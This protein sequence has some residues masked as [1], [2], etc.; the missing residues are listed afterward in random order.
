MLLRRLPPSAPLG[1]LLAVLGPLLPQR[2]PAAD[3]CLD[4]HDRKDVGNGNRSVHP[5]FADDDCQ[6]CHLDHGDE[7]RLVL[8]ADGN[9]LCDSCHDT[10]ERAFL[11]AHRDVRGPKARCISCHDPHRSAEEQLLTPNRHRPLAFGRCDPC[12]RY[13]GR[14]TKPVGELCLGCH[15]GEEFTRR[16]A[17]APVR[18]GECLSC[19]DPHASREP[20][21]L[22]ARY[23]PGRG[24]GGE[25]DVALCLRCHDRAGYFD[26]G[27]ERT[28]FRAGGRNY[29]ALHLLAPVASAAGAGAG[30]RGLSCRACHEVHTSEGPRLVR[31]ELDCGGVPCLRLDFRRT[32][33][34]GHCL[35]GCHASQSYSFS[36]GG[37]P[38]PAAVQALLLAQEPTY[39]SPRAALLEP[40]ALEE[41]INRRCVGCH[42]KDV[43][44]FARGRGHAPVQSG[45]CSSCH[46]DHGPE[47]RLVL[48]GP[49]DRVCARCHDLRGEAAATAHRGYP[50][51]GSRCTECHDPHGAEA[52]GLVLTRRHPPF[53]EGDCRSCH[54]EPARGWRI[55]GGGRDTCGQC[56][57]EI[58]RGKHRH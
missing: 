18:R 5:P 37:E 28:L 38:L 30:A 19:H 48:L 51:E 44:R 41:S 26:G 20:F 4:C 10:Q 46:L 15:G 8:S 27:A 36:R 21:L 9:A 45:A 1:I 52:A 11:R 39:R 24:S 42:E 16:I 17:H 53:E 57:D 54:G 47:N 12:H 49:E 7:G 23:A 34:G 14:L 13:D 43:R 58:G 33:T 25:R 40:T 2:L 6:A 29:H 31:R 35:S 22:T 32:D 3:A 50:L 56:H 55:A